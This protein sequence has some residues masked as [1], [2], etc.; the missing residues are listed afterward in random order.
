MLDRDRARRSVDGPRRGLK[1][2]QGLA[3]RYE[4]A[5]PQISAVE[6][7]L[8]LFSAV[9]ANCLDL[10]TKL[11][12]Y[13]ASLDARDRFGARPLSHAARSGHLEMVDLLLARGAPIN[14]R[15]LADAPA[16]YFAAEGGHT[17]IVHRLIERGAER[18]E[19]ESPSLLPLMPA[20]TPLSK[21]CSL[22]EPTSERQTKPASR[23]LSMRR[24]RHGSTS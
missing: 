12:D 23:R 24:P 17:P 18:G 15:S 4:T 2:C 6:V 9:D 7:S 5:K 3:R 13:G 21:R 20:T 16:L 11:L 8:T 19:R 1:R 22:A 10:A 14:A